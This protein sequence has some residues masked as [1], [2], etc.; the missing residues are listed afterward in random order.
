MFSPTFE[1]S[2]I[3]MVYIRNTLH[4]MYFKMSQFAIYTESTA[5]SPASYT[6]LIGLDS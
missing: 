3:H 5:L 2:Y 6:A 1:I 4:V